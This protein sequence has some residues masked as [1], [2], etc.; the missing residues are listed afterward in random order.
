MPEA[1]RPWQHV[2][3]PLYG[4]ILLV[5][6]LCSKDGKKNIGAWNFGPSKKQN[7]PVLKFAKLFR[8]KMNSKSKIAIKRS[9]NKLKNKKVKIFESK[10]LSINSKKVY[11]SLNWSPFLS[12]ESA[13]NLTIEW[14]EAFKKRQNL[15]YLTK[16]Q[17]LN[18]IKKFS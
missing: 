6:K 10:N 16:L 8:K 7:L 14:Y 2:I 12:I 1:T 5:Q 11:K 3:E 9:F 4:Y 13:I 17:I 18:Y 15:L